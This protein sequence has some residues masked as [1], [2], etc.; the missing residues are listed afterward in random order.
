MSIKAM[1]TEDDL[2]SRAILVDLL[3]DHF[4]NVK[5]IGMTENVK[6]SVAFLND[7]KIDLLFLDLELPDGK[8]FDILR[9]LQNWD[10]YV[11]VTTS[12][13][14]YAEEPGSLNVLYSIIKPLTR[15]SLEKAMNR[16]QWNN[17]FEKVI[18]YGLE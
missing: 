4:P 8:G 9:S 16:Y 6:D 14:K 2:L 10:F 15:Q 1:I 13:A 7:H 11:I 3:E 18:H 12:Y 5:I 17:K